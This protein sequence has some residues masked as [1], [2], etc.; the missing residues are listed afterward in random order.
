MKKIFIS[1]VFVLV[2]IIAFASDYSTFNLDNGQ[3]LIIKE[4]H[5]KPIVIIDM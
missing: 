4:V 1:V 3:K 2:G 5:D